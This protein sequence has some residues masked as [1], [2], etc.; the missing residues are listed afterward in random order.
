M[1]H[2]LVSYM[3]G[4]YL[5]YILTTVSG[6]PNGQLCCWTRAYAMRDDT[7]PQ[8]IVPLRMW[9]VYSEMQTLYCRRLTFN[10][11]KHTVSRGFELHISVQTLR[12]RK[13]FLYAGVS[14]ILYV[15]SFLTEGRTTLK[16]IFGQNRQANFVTFG[17]IATALADQCLIACSILRPFFSMGLHWSFNRVM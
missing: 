12:R 6:I 3:L 10:V 9:F 11:T 8:G 17:N 1:S 4:G 7:G 13:I 14:Q 15:T 5:D 16:H 2:A